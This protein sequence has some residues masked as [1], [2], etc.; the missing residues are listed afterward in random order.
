MTSLQK[1]FNARYDGGRAGYESPDE[2]PEWDAA[3]YLSR[4]R[5]LIFE[6]EELLG[7][8]TGIW[9]KNRAKLNND[10]LEALFAAV[11]SELDVK[12][13]LV[14]SIGGDE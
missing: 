9:Q 14:D 4:R 7:F 6:L 3:E 8:R 2:R 10:D 5:K 12:P 11:I 13:C 1:A